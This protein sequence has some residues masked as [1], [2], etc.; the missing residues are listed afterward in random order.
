MKKIILA[1]GLFASL[2][3]TGC[4]SISTHLDPSMEFRKDYR[5]T[6]DNGYKLPAIPVR[7]IDKKYLRQIVD[8]QTR[9]RPGT[10]VVSVKE[11]FLYLV[12]PGGKAVRY[13]I[14]VGKQGFAWSGNAYV[15]WKAEW[16]T[17]TPPGPMLKRKPELRKY[18]GGMKP[19]LNNPLGARAM[20]LMRN[21]QD[22][23]YRLHG[24]PEW[25]TIGTAASSGCIR[26]MNQDIIDLH[27]RVKSGAK[28]VVRQS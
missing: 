21:G 9:E 18:A 25:W 14:G 27:S 22:T 10:V 5:R 17:W 3:I 8:Y 28:V 6:T 4:T 19:G 1:A 23:M 26:L 16:P 7:K 15:G 11:R 13:G 20:Y 12:Q 2:T 24:T